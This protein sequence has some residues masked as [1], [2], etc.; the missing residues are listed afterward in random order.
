MAITD[1]REVGDRVSV[2]HPS[3]PGVW[4]IKSRGP[5]N[6]VLTPEGGGRGLKVPHD[7]LIDPGHT[8]DDPAPTVYFV[9]GEFVRIPS[10]KFAGLYVVTSDR[11]GKTVSITKPG[12]DGGRYVRAGRGGLV[13]V[14]PESVIAGW[15]AGGWSAV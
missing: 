7:M 15:S 11:G 9:P 8:Y 5:V 3:Y 2:N 13:K 12:G 10:G 1:N 4:I 14:D 6:T